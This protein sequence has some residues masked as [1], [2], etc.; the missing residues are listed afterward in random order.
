MREVLLSQDGVL[1]EL[2]KISVK[3]ERLL[4]S[5]EIRDE[6]ISEKFGNNFQFYLSTSE[7]HSSLFSLQTY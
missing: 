5:G 6:I 7:K 4:S 3:K 1:M 2:V